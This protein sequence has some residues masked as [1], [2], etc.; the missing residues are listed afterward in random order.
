MFVGVLTLFVDD[1]VGWLR[2]AGFG[3]IVLIS[4]FLSFDFICGIL[5]FVVVVSCAACSV[6][7]GF[8]LCWLLVAAGLAVWL[9]YLVW[10]LCCL[11]VCGLIPSCCE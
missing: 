11:R 4:S 8:W 1:C 3:L 2:L 5:V 9:E 7:F 6:L 10:W